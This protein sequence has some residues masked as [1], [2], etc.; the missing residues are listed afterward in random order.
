MKE[1]KVWDIWVRLFHWLLVVLIVVQFVTGYVGEN[2]LEWHQRVGYVV[3]G[4]IVF[5]VLWGFAGSHHARFGNFL[6]GPRA[7]ASYVK[8]LRGNGAPHLGHN[9]MGALSV[10]AMLLA[11]AVQAATGLFANDDVM[12]EGPWASLVS[13]DVSDFLTKVHKI[14]SNVLIA[15]VVLHL[16]AVAYYF[17]VKK[18]NLVKAMFTGKKP[19][20]G[21]APMVARPIWLAPLIAV[22]TAIAIFLLVKK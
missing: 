14:N 8:E 16:L 21:E 18:E 22:L 20:E 3:L 2:W 1:A 17:F 6:R 15:L 13:K 11:I 19:F 9:P 5:R 7:I 4:L 10:I 12:L